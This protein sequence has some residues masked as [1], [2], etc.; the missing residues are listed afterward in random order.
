MPLG[1]PGPVGEPEA[2]ELDDAEHRRAVAALVPQVCHKLNNTIGVV[3][4]L[5]ELLARKVADEDVTH[6]LDTVFQQASHAAR[7]VG[8]LGDYAT[9][10]PSG[11]ELVDVDPI[12]AEARELLAPVAQIAG[13]ELELRS[14]DSVHLA[15]VD[16]RRLTQAI[17][18][19]VVLGLDG[20][21]EARARLAVASAPSGVVLRVATRRAGARPVELGALARSFGA[22]WSRRERSGWSCHRLALAP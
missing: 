22:R 4:G 11:A 15:R 13:V 16:R 1:S 12:L 7:Q 10:R 9:A 21:G 20:R 5:A 14:D 2:D 17:V 3:Q 19:A 6:Q 18:T 8:R